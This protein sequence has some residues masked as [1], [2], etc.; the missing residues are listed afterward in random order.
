MI[1]HTEY[2]T[3]TTKKRYEIIDITEHVEKVRADAG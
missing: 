2:V 3:F 1:A